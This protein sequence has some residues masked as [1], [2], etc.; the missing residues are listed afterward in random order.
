MLRLRQL[1]NNDCEPYVHMIFLR[2]VSR[3]QRVL[4]GQNQSMPYGRVRSCSIAF[5]RTMG[6]R[7]EKVTKKVKDNLDLDVLNA[8]NGNVARLWSSIGTKE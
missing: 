2:M 6:F 5:N 3:T 7:A 1:E 4:P 8:L